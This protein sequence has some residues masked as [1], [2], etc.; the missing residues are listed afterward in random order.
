MTVDLPHCRVQF[1]IPHR[2]SV[3]KTRRCTSSAVK[4]SLSLTQSWGRPSFFVVCRLRSSPSGS[5]QA[6]GALLDKSVNHIPKLPTKNPKTAAP[7]GAITTALRHISL[8]YNTITPDSHIPPD[9][10]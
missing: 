8:I 2:A 10:L 4:P 7:A 9:M 1:K 5:A 6:T 3:S